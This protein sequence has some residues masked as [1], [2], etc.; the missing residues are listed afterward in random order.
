MK[1][2]Y[3]V[4]FKEKLQAFYVPCNGI[5]FITITFKEGLSVAETVAFFRAF[6]EKIKRELGIKGLT[7]FYSF[8]LHEKKALH[9]HLLLNNSIGEKLKKKLLEFWN[10]KNG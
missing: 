7:Y 3:L 2:D 1:V 6:L 10:K 9:V 5:V 4:E 8:E